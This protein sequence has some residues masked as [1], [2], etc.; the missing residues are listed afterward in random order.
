MSKSK[1]VVE[2]TVIR[3][4]IATVVKRD[5]DNIFGIVRDT[6]Y[7]DSLRQLRRE[8][9]IELYLSLIAIVMLGVVCWYFFIVSNN[10]I[11]L[12]YYR[13]GR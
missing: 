9:R 12:P 11:E 2:V 1:N 6:S 10:N 13:T 3:N 7:E 8:E 5:R 4:N